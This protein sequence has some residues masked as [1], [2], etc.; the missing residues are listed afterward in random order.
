MWL[1]KVEIGDIADHQ[2]FECKV[3]DARV[4]RTVPHISDG[5]PLRAEEPVRWQER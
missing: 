3:C 1:V 2:Q 5:M 4:K